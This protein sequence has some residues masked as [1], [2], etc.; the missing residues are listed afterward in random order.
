MQFTRQTNPEFVAFKQSAEAAL[1]ADPELTRL[2]CLNPIKAIEHDFDFSLVPEVEIE[3]AWRRFL[4]LRFDHCAFSLGVRDTLTDLFGVLSRRGSTLALPSDVYP[5]YG[6]IAESVGLRTIDYPTLPSLNVEAAL[7]A[8]AVLITAP[9]VPL[10]RDLTA[11]EVESLLAWLRQSPNRLLVLDRVYDYDRPALVQPLIDSNQAIVC[12]SLSKT[13]LSPLTMG[14]AIVPPQ[15][16]E[17]LKTSVPPECE[18]AKVLLTRYRDFPRWQQSIFRHRWRNLDGIPAPSTGYL[19]VVPASHREL[20]D[21]GILAIPGEV[22]GASNDLSVVSCL[23]ETNRFGGTEVVD[24]FYATALSNFA[25]GYDKYSRR[26]SKASIPESTYPDRF[27]LLEESQRSIGLNKAARLLEKT[28]AGDRVI[29][30]G[31]R[32]R[33][34]ELSPNLRTGLGEYVERDW[35]EVCSVGEAGGASMSVEE[36]Y[37]ASLRL[38][39]DLCPWEAVRPR[40][41]S[42]LPIAQ[43][44][45]ARC[46]FCFSHSSLSDDQKQGRIL[47]AKLEAFCAESRRRGADRFVI[48]GGGEPTLLAHDKLLGL[49]ATAAR[50]FPTLVMIT[51]GHYLGHATPDERLRALDDYHAN[52]LNVLSISRHSPDRNAEI[53]GLDTCSERVAKTW[54]ENRDRLGGLRLRWV[55]VL[56]KGGVSD[57]VSLAAYLDWVAE[58]GVEEVCFK[59]L[60][61]AASSESR[62]SE[63]EYNSWCARHQVPLSLVVDFLEWNGGVR[64]GELPWGAP[65]YSLRWRGRG[66]RVA[67]YTEPSV[68]WERKHGIGRSWNLM[69]DGSCYANLETSDSRV[70]LLGVL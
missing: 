30:L 53:M 14:L 19:S 62:Y 21:R 5:V 2:D 58:T 40:S 57:E 66:I 39:P 4:N 27:Y 28:V 60:Y 9:C 69:A 70:D 20:L 59:E 23:H 34:H 17:A 22:Y 15:W 37:A 26:Y 38:N 32:V 67:A 44:C 7:A 12:Y 36:A 41:L 33:R 13:F 29:V 64:C 48:T 16:A 68:Y 45:Q 52:G 18:K 61:V 25:R 63:S 24:R 3:D 1:R 49:M 43:A 50:H 47:L 56:Q 54:K 65:I 35:V 46:R 55:G 8:D 31:T 10:G 51:N 11:A 6:K 42:V